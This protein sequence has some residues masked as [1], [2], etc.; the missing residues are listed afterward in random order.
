MAF[1]DIEILFMDQIHIQQTKTS[2][3]IH[4]NIILFDFFY[5]KYAAFLK[6]F[7]IGLASGAIVHIEVFRRKA[8]T[9]S[10]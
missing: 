8:D 10:V 1:S 3:L 4:V 6:R 7:D 5:K 2:K 9:I